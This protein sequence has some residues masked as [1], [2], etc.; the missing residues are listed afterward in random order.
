MCADLLTATG[1]QVMVI[2]R[3]G[4]AKGSTPATTAL[5]QYDLDV[6]LTQLRRSLGSENAVRAWRRARLAVDN[7]HNDIRTA[8]SDL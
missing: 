4:M 5:V 3:R 1:H 6:P 8:T 2:D 7:S